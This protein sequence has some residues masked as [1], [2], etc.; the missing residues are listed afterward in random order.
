VSGGE[1]VKVLEETFTRLGVQVS[2]LDRRVRVI[3]LPES[4]RKVAEEAL[5]LGFDHLVSIEGIDWPQNNTIEVVYHAE[6]YN[7]DLR[8]L[9]L[10]IRVRVPR[11]NPRLESLIDVWPNAILLERETWEM[12]GVVFEGN[13]D[14]RHLLLPPWW[15]EIPPLRKDYKV[16]EEGIYVDLE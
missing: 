6:S 5:S 9:L 8:S 15:S 11:D 2:V 14:L 1:K 13:P 7:D 12:L 10:E 4:L 16:Q 3:A